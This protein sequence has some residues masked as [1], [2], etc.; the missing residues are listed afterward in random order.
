MYRLFRGGPNLVAAH[1]VTPLWTLE[2]RSR[3]GKTASPVSPGQS[4]KKT[5]FVTRG[6]E[7]S[8]YWKSPARPRAQVTVRASPPR[9]ET[10]RWSMAGVAARRDI[11]GSVTF[12]QIRWRLWIRYR[13]EERGAVSARSPQVRGFRRRFPRGDPIFRNPGPSA[14]FPV[15]WQRMASRRA[16]GLYFV[17]EDCQGGYLNHSSRAIIPMRIASSSAVQSF[18]GQSRRRCRSL[19]A[20]YDIAP[21]RSP[22]L[23]GCRRLYAAGGS[24]RS[25]QP[26]PSR[27]SS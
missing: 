15:F 27:E 20:P 3:H 22:R 19:Y 25:G 18:P 9:A 23:V 17:A 11:S 7:T 14:K 13:A 1:P 21:A 12:P 26:G 24:I 4:D 16:A 10:V 6:Y 8:G 2:V 5:S